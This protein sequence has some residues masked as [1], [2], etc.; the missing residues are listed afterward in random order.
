MVASP[1][2]GGRRPYATTTQ[3]TGDT[4]AVTGSPSTYAPAGAAGSP[5]HGEMPPVGAH[6]RRTVPAPR[7]EGFAPPNCPGPGQTRPPCQLAVERP[8]RSG[9]PVPPS[10]VGGGA[11]ACFGG[12]PGLQGSRASGRGSADIRTNRCESTTDPPPLRGGLTID[13]PVRLARTGTRRTSRGRGEDLAR[14]LPLRLAGRRER[15]CANS[16]QAIA[17]ARPSPVDGRAGI[18]TTGL[19]KRVLRGNSRGCQSS[20]VPYG[21]LSGAPRY[22]SAVIRAEG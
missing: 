1:G 16:S 9:V 17:T 5:F 12:P 22:P 14:G 6:A 15:T 18:H 13:P 20:A 10:V 11:G 2:W 19:L 4:S 3:A 21:V 7:E 8:S